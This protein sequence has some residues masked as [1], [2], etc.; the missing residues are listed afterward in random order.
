MNVAVVRVQHS[1]RFGQRALS[2]TV[3]SPSSSIRFLVKYVPPAAGIGRF[4]HSGSRRFGASTASAST[5]AGRAGRERQSEPAHPG[6]G[7]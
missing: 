6:L 1:E 7:A 4:S 3:S 2:Q 5:R